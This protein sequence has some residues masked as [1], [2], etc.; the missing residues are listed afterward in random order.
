MRGEGTSVHLS[1]SEPQSTSRTRGTTVAVRAHG[2]RFGVQCGINIRLQCEA[3]EARV[4]P[5][6]LT[7]LFPRQAELLAVKRETKIDLAAPTVMNSDQWVWVMWFSMDFSIYMEKR[8]KG[9]V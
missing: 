5:P 3:R 6:Q 1:R 7:V 4:P 2:L 8:S 9:A